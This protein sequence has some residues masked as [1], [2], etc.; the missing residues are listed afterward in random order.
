MKI[1]VVVFLLMTSMQVVAQN[2]EPAD[3]IFLNGDV[4]TGAV[5]PYMPGAKPPAKPRVQAIAV[6]NGRILSIGTNEEVRKYAAK[7]THSVD[8]RGQF[9][10]PGFNDAHLHLANGGF[11]KLNVDLVGVKSLDEM[12]S[13]IAARVKTASPGEWILGRGWDHTAWTGKTLPSRQDLD[14]VTAGHP[15]YFVRVDGHIA[16]ANSAALKAAGVGKDTKAPSGGTI[17]RDS[18]GEATG[19][20]RESAQDLVTSK[21]PHPTAEQRRRGLELAFA[22]AV[23]HGITSVQDNSSWDDFL[24]MEDMQSDGVLPIRV[25]EWLNFND[26]VETLQQH[27]ARHPQTDPHLHTGMLKGY[28]DGSLGSRTA[29]LLAPYSDDPHNTGLP[30]FDQEKLN[31]MTRERVAAGFQIG[32]HAIGDNGVEMALEAFE[33]ATTAIRENQLRH[34]NTTQRTDDF[35][36]RI[37]HDQVVTAEQV[38]RYEQLGVIASVQPN[39]LLTDMNWAEERIGPAR[40]KVSYPWADYVKN[41]VMLAFG[42]DYPVE[43]ITPFRGVYAAVT[44]KNEAGTKTYYPEQKLTIEQ[45]IAAYTTGAAYAEF[46]ERDKGLIQAGM[47]ADFVVLDRD[48]TKVAPEEILKTKVLRTVVAGKTVFNAE[49]KTSK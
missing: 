14:A 8:L 17:D 44:R 33:D 1:I 36:L 4:Y 9:V 3:I 6:K 13:R 48:L 39:H 45:A 38:P 10:M 40:A 11:E 47:L 27:R 22:D 41:K 37:E 16:V 7:K 31:R 18:N 29:A 15:A 12:K 28:M 23:R 2:S 46:A 21:I 34:P 35:R 19:I 24:V 49:E 26:S 43:P 20:L 5:L 25:T 30:Q 42:T 32:F